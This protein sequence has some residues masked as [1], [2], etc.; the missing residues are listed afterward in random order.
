MYKAISIHSSIL[1]DLTLYLER[2]S[3]VLLAYL[4]GKYRIRYWIE[5]HFIKSAR[6]IFFF[7]NVLHIGKF[8]NI[9]IKATN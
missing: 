2:C 3:F 4:G 5:S 7:I 1:N 9:F 6:H 8:K